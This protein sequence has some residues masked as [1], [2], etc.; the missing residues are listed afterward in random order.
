[1]TGNPERSAVPSPDPAAKQR[2]GAYYL[3]GLLQGSGGKAWNPESSSNGLGLDNADLAMI[4]QARAFIPEVLTEKLNL[5]KLTWRPVA[6]ISHEKPLTWL[7]TGFSD[8]K[9]L[10]IDNALA[11]IEIAQH[12]RLENGQEKFSPLLLRIA[13]VHNDKVT[14]DKRIVAATYDLTEN[15]QLTNLNV[16]L[17][18]QEFDSLSNGAERLVFPEHVI[19]DF[20][21]QSAKP[22]ST[23]GLITNGMVNEIRS[24]NPQEL[25]CKKAIS[26]RRNQE[27]AYR[28]AVKGF[29]R[30]AISF[31]R[32]GGEKSGY[33]VASMDGHSL[34]V[35]FTNPEDDL[36]TQQRPKSWEIII[37]SSLQKA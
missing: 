12:A 26:I 33:Y 3:K 23:A 8:A 5:S 28:F 25:L 10:K 34:N 35:G 22:Y 16:S 29:D 21:S 32:S 19:V 37:P 24:K 36:N 20:S 13:G 11:T 1:M 15:G 18:N 9:E 17:S 27:G 31:L 14:R 2:I 30:N 4:H 7:A 6:L